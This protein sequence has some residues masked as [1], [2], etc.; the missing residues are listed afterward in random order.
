MS[1]S[2][3]R[4]ETHRWVVRARSIVPPSLRQ[5]HLGYLLSVMGDGVSAS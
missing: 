5:A 3:S 4:V 1:S 2:L